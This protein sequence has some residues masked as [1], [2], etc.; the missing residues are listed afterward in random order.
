MRLVRHRVNARPGPRHEAPLL[1]GGLWMT[2]C[3]VGLATMAWVAG[4]GSRGP[5]YDDPWFGRDAALS[6]SSIDASVDADLDAAVPCD[7]EAASEAIRGGGVG[8]LELDPADPAQRTLVGL[9]GQ[10]LYRSADGGSTWQLR[11]EL[12]AAPAALAFDGRTLLVATDDGIRASSDDGLTFEARGLRGLAVSRLA[13]APGHASRVYGVVPGLGV[14]RSNDGGV[15]WV[16]A[17][18]GIVGWVHRLSVD[19]RDPDV[20]VAT[21]ILLDA[22]GGFS[23][24]G[25]VLRTTNGGQS[26]TELDR[27]GGRSYD[28]ARCA[29]DPSV[30]VAV[31]RWGMFRSS[32]GGATFVPMAGAGEQVFF[33][34]T[35]DGPGCTHVV[36]FSN[37][38]AAGFGMYVSNDGS[39]FTG[40]FTEGF[41]MSR[42]ARADPVL[43]ALGGGRIVAGTVS[44]PFVS[45]DGGQSYFGGGDFLALFVTTFVESEGVLWAGTYGSGLWSLAPSE[46]AWRRVPVE[47]LDND[48]TFGLL[49]F[50]GA[51]AERGRV[52]VGSWGELVGRAEGGARFERIPNDGSPADNVFAFARLADGTLLSASQIEGIQRSDDGGATFHFSNDGIVPWS[53]PLGVLADMRALA[54]DPARPG[55]VIAGG[56]G[57]GL[58]RSVDA[59][60]TWVASGLAEES[61]RELAFSPALGSFSAVV[62]GEGVFESSDGAAW[63]DVSSGLESLDVD[64]LEIADDGTRY[65]V[66]GG[67]VYRRAPGASAWARVP[68]ACAP[69]DARLPRVVSRADGRWLYVTTGLDGFARLRL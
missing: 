62:L 2:R 52:I 61:V 34:A 66:S 50:G 42:S 35:V 59:G 20:V 33:S 53:T 18:R 39:H 56:A 60:R 12:D 64:G 30:L 16:A 47:V 9:S 7:W 58:W 1:A 14:V 65:A 31:R 68:G 8:A 55:L 29:E 40:P 67:V 49:P 48:Y 36:A 25:Q 5:I 63:A 19:P 4:C 43:R 6:R 32:D 17:N 45:D 21:S 37:T 27:V 13:T 54:V 26:W 51:T 22:S 23:A 24:E 38:P 15:S 57:G 28:L 10:R 41:A 3:W 44:G 46:S 11:G 69:R